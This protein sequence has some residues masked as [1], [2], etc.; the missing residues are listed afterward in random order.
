MSR[1]WISGVVSCV[2]SEH[3]ERVDLGDLYH[4][5]GSE[6]VVAAEDVGQSLCLVSGGYQ[7]LHRAVVRLDRQPVLAPLGVLQH[8]VVGLLV[9]ELVGHQE[10]QH[11][12]LFPAGSVESTQG[13]PAARR[14]EAAS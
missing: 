5:D 13:R 9:V 1:C 12:G 8:A 3:L 4:D 6:A 7:H 10:A 14:L 2:R 11:V